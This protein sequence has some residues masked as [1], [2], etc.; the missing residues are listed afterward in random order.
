MNILLIY[1]EFPDTFWSFKHA[2]KFIRKKASFPPLGLLTVAAMLP[3][4]WSKRLVDVNVTRLTDKDLAWADYAFIS[5]MVVQRISARHIIRRCREANVKVVAGGP[6]FTSE[7]EQFEDVD[8]FVLNEAEMTLPSFLEDL[9]NNCARRTYSTS[10]FA[11]IRKTPAPLWELA[12]L[13]QYASMS[14]QYSRGCPYHCEFCNV[15]ALFGRSPRTKTAEQIVAEM[16]SFY[17]L[18][19]RGPVFFVDDNLIGNKKDLKNELLPALIK[20]QREHVSIP[21]HTEVSINLAD[22]ESLMQMMS[23]AGF[24]AVFVGIETPDT[25][26]LAECNKKQNKNRNLIEDVRRIQRAGLQV[27]AGFIVG[28]DNDTPSIFQR[29]IDFIQKSGIVSAMI[30]LLQAPAGTKLYE[31]LKREGRLLGQMSGDNVDGTTNIIPTMDIDTFREGY[32]NILRYIYSPENYYQRIKTFFREYKAPKIKAQFT[33][34]HIL[35]LFRAIYHLGIL[36][37]ERVQFWEL[38]LWTYFHRREL[39][40][41][42]ITLAVYGYHFRKV[43]KLHVL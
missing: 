12:D 5:S 6:L 29:Q 7:H 30:G 8:H 11:D 22:D 40:P 38:L 20:W 32:K 3:P 36:G 27:Q 31:R 16:D 43:S 35:A 4:E 10:H 13:R 26:S 15:T 18:G 25:D 9:K 1:P 23:D 33:F 28:F 42:S 17:R 2:L 34:N 37:N 41:L 21:F 14:I 19:W 39:L 24:D